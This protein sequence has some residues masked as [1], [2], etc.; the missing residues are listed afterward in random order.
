MRRW[1]KQV[2]AVVNRRPRR[3]KLRPLNHSRLY[4]ANVVITRAQRIRLRCHQVNR[5]LYC[6][7]RAVPAHGDGSPAAALV[8]TSPAP[9]VP[10]ML[11][12][13]FGAH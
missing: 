12:G 13:D 3:Q 10:A 5:C 6:S 7:F 1:Q 9:S 4:R 8:P 11:V 2:S